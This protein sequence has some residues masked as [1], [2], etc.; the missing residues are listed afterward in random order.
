MVDDD[1]DRSAQM[2]IHAELSLAEPNRSPHTHHLVH[3]PKAGQAA[4][5]RIDLTL[6]LIPSGG[7]RALTSPSTPLSFPVN[8][9]N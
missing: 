8:T 3:Q 9:P 2:T 5:T 6:M 1:E 4:I 7:R